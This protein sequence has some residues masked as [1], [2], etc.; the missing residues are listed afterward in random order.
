M[1]RVRRIPSQWR[2]IYRP[3]FR[4]AQP[5]TGSQFS[6]GKT[7]LW[8]GVVVVCLFALGSGA[9]FATENVSLTPLP[10]SINNFPIFPGARNIKITEPTQPYE[11]SRLATFTTAA[12]QDQIIAYY[13][14]ILSREG[15][16]GPGNG[17]HSDDGDY[18]PFFHSRRS[19]DG[20]LLSDYQ[21]GISF[22]A[23]HQNEVELSVTDHLPMDCLRHM[24]P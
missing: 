22:S 19:L 9:V 21:F 6:V 5:N 7:L 12:T 16:T 2:G 14:D 17:G 4:L 20:R 13:T 1:Y 23:A 8:I 11:C 3:R 15:W 18:F 24:I 10:N